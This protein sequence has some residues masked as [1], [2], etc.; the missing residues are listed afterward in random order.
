MGDWS[1]A[2]ED[3]DAAADWYGHLFDSTRLAAHVEEALN[4]DPDSE[5]DVIRAAAFVLVQ[6]GRVYIWPVDEMDRH[7]KLAIQKLEAIRELEEFQE[8]D[9]LVAEID[10]EISILRSRLRPEDRLDA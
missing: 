5:P 3:N 6:L 8:V 4:R 9:G 7:L 10:N 2:A 1:L